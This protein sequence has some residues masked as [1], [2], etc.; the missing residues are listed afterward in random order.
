MKI[1]N[2]QASFSVIDPTKS[3][4][5]VDK[6][7][8]LYPRQQTAQSLAAAIFS[9]VYYRARG[10]A[11]S[12]ARRR[13]PGLK[14]GLQGRGGGGG[15]SHSICPRRR[16]AP[17]AYRAAGAA[18]ARKS[19]RGLESSLNRRRRRAARYYP[20]D[21]SMYLGSSAALAQFVGSIVFCIYGDKFR[22]SACRRYYAGERNDYSSRVFVV[23]ARVGRL[24]LLSRLQAALGVL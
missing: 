23:R 4:S 22:S 20:K 1:K 3:S 6:K 21:K 5:H 13:F 17:A 16:I 11:N 12:R 15:G 19:R 10:K 18:F 24:S 9:H 2:L 7:R 14:T 8:P